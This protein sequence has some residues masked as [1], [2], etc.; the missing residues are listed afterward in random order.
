VYDEDVGS[1]DFVGYRIIPLR[2]LLSGLRSVALYNKTHHLIDF[3]SL[4]I[5]VTIS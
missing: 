2:V 3:A 1:D 4:L 5:R